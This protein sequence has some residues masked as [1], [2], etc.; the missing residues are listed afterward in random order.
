[1]QN[2]R[3]VIVYNI[4]VYF[5]TM[6]YF[7]SLFRLGELE[8]AVKSFTV[9]LTLDKFFLDA[10]V[11]RG[12]VFMDFHHEMGLRYARYDSLHIINKYLLF[13]D[14]YNVLIDT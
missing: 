11:S 10:L 9:A 14:T 1:M 8:R 6:I 7:I 3:D 13:E 5:F 2:Q 12:N 4:A